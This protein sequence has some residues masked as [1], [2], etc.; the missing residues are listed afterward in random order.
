MR[1]SHIT[2][3]QVIERRC[4]LTGGSLRKI[5]SSF[6]LLHTQYGL[7]AEIYI[8]SPLRNRFRIAKALGLGFGLSICQPRSPPPL[9]RTFHAFVFPKKLIAK[10][11]CRI[12]RAVFDATFISIAIDITEGEREKKCIAR[13]GLNLTFNRLE[14]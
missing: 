9:L 6:L 4:N 2:S 1:C 11:Q 7:T 12:D 13:A 3:G 8:Q 10:K 5:R 14:N